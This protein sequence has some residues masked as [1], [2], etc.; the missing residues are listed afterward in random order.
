M[1]FDL[2][3][4]VTKPWAVDLSRPLLG[5]LHSL[6]QGIAQCHIPFPWCNKGLPN[7]FPILMIA[8]VSFWESRGNRTYSTLHKY[9]SKLMTF[10]ALTWPTAFDYWQL[11][12][13][14]STG[15]NMLRF[16]SSQHPLLLQLHLIEMFYLFFPLAKYIICEIPERVYSLY[17]WLDLSHNHKPRVSIL[18]EASGSSLLHLVVNSMALFYF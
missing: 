1:Q 5:S 14:Q 10:C 2:S 4:P 18:W 7:V 6:F 16:H 17:Y 15:L 12:K 8:R 13:P 11:N 9:H 3:L